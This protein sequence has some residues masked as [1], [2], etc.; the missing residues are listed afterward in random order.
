M[1]EYIN[2][3]IKYVMP[4]EDVGINLSSPIATVEFDVYIP[5]RF[6]I[7]VKEDGSWTRV[8]EQYDEEWR[9]KHFKISYN[10]GF[11]DGCK[12]YEN[13]H[14]DKVKTRPV[15]TKCEFY[16]FNEMSDEAYCAAKD[17]K[18]IRLYRK[19]RPNWCP[20]LKKERIVDDS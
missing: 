13:N 8:R 15:C 2:N 3:E 18:P 7:D 14:K 4:G 5:G 20:R 16:D 10:Q 9:K 1:A 17:Y 6:I 12:V 19:H 11:V